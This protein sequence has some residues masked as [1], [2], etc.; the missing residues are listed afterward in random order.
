MLGFESYEL[1]A[2]DGVSDASLKR[3]LRLV[4]ELF[5]RG[6]DRDFRFVLETADRADRL[7]FPTLVGDYVRIDPARP[8]HDSELVGHGTFPEHRHSFRITNN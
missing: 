4:M 7:V 1:A 3:D 5:L 6:R 2:F 8:A